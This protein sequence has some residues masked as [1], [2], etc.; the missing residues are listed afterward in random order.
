MSKYYVKLGVIISA[1][2]PISCDFLVHSRIKNNS[3]DLG[4]SS[5]HDELVTWEWDNVFQVSEVSRINIFKILT[6]LQFQ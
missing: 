2:C 1:L 5:S 6:L 4:Y 3:V